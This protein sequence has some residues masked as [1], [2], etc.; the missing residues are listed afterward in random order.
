M[1]YS[2]SKETDKEVA[3]LIKGIEVDARRRANSD[4]KWYDTE[5]QERAL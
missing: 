3:S 4:A 1:I 2:V 5:A